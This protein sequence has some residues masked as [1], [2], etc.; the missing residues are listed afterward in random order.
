MNWDYVAGFFDG[1]GGT[2][3]SFS[4]AKYKGNTNWWPRV[5]MSIS[6]TNKDVLLEIS[7]FFKSQGITCG[8]YCDKATDR[9]KYLTLN[10]RSDYY[11]I[12]VTSIDSMKKLC[13]ELKDRVVSKSKVIE[14]T[15]SALAFI[16]QNQRRKWAYEDKKFFESKYILPHVALVRRAKKHRVF[17]S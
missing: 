14:I 8:L 2:S 12:R 15:D 11:N 10:V 13:S 3:V 4:S 1:E 16:L 7:D 17:T 9:Q 5:Q 6:N